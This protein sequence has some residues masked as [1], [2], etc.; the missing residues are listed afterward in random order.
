VPED[1][2]TLVPGPFDP[3]LAAAFAAGLLL[4]GG[5]W[6][7]H[8]RLRARDAAAASH[9]LNRSEARIEELEAQVD[10]LREEVRERVDELAARRETA[11]ELR[12]R[13]EETRKHF[14]EKEAALEAN[15][16]ALKR[17]FE[18]LA[19][20]VFERQG[21]QHSAR[22]DTVLEPFKAQLS[23]FRQRVDAVYST[24]S[25][26]RASLLTEVRNLQQA[27][28]R[29]RG[30]TEHLARALRGDV[31]AQ[32]NWGELVLERVLESSGLR[33]NTEYFL[34]ESRR[35]DDGSLK[36]PDVLIRLPDDKDVVVDAKLSLTAYEQ[37]LALEEPAAR[38]A[39]LNQ[40]VASLRGH[41]K[42]RRSR[43]TISSTGCA[44][45][46]SCCCSCP[47]RRPSVRP[48]STT[49]A[50]SRKPSSGASSSSAPP[51]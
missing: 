41:V 11:A 47:S 30:E 14:A 18:V 27:S 4:A 51:P 32:G 22:L 48:W 33:R 50:C 24:E 45:W 29:I 25:K 23:D 39:A 35:A 1:I 6:W 40:H 28:D 38:T 15:G 21:A 17:E 46:T 13:L 20:R 42:R 49:S 43:T 5:G 10:A 16:A 31:K 8:L 44:V 9:A 2:A 36:R 3:W 7:L 19:N 26:D 12:T 37:A 34:Q